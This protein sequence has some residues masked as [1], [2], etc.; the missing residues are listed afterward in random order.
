[1]KLTLTNESRERKFNLKNK[2]R[3]SQKTTTTTTNNL[4][5]IIFK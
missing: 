5:Y 2:T 1:M 3:K 4:N